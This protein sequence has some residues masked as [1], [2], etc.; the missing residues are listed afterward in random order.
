MADYHINLQMIINES[1]DRS[2]NYEDINAEKIEVRHSD[3][4]K[5]M[6]KKIGEASRVLII[7]GAGVGK[8]TLMKYMSYQ[9]SV[10]NFW[11]DKFDYVY[12]L[13]LK[14][15]LDSGWMQV[16]KNEDSLLK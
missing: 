3:I 9:W 7:G 4:F 11:Q 1:D 8:S 10:G 16:Y 2:T 13:S 5:S 6:G 14:T 15:L 12:R